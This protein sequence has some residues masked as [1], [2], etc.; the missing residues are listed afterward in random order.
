MSPGGKWPLSFFQK[1]L[2]CAAAQAAVLAEKSN[3]RRQPDK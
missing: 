1:W 2:I 3:G